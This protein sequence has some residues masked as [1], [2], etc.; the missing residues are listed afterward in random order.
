[1]TLLAIRLYKQVSQIY[2]DKFVNLEGSHFKRNKHRQDAQS[3]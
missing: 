3:P 2:K 1:M